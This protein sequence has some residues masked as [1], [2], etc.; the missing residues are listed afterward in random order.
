M[1]ITA[2]ES[3]QAGG[4]QREA[5]ET[6]ILPAGY[7]QEMKASRSNRR[8]AN[9][10]EEAIAVATAAVAEIPDIRED[11]V[12]RIKGEIERGEYQVTG[13]EVADMMLR[14]MKADSIR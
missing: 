12:A 10:R 4:V 9:S 2:T 8:P 13:E 1:K 11:V 7:R 3:G 6:A 14:R 5:A